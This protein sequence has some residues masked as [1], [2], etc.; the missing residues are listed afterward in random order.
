MLNIGLTWKYPTRKWD[1]YHYGG[2]L[3]LLMYVDTPF[4]A[5]IPLVRLGDQ[6]AE[7][8]ADMILVGR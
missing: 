5:P 8:I 7:L 6:E 1:D 4:S 3:P 2:Y